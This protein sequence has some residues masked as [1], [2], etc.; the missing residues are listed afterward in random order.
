MSSSSGGPDATTGQA[1]MLGNDP[2]N[3]KI[4]ALGTTKGNPRPYEGRYP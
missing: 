4:K 3:L 1:V 2:L